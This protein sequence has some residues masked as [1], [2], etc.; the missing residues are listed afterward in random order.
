MK[1]KNISKANMSKIPP[2]SLIPRKSPKLENLKAELWLCS[3]AV[4]V[5]RGDSLS[6]DLKDYG[7]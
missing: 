7:F 1:T 6:H 2:N 3:H 5:G 4:P